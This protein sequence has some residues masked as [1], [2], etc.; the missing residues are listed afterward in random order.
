MSLEDLLNTLLRIQVWDIVK[1]LL[2]TALLI[3][4]IFALITIRQVELM[5]H[6]VGIT[7]TPALRLIAVVHFFISVGIF[8]LALFIL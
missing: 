6:V 2:E 7:L 3:Y 8:L 1:V 4:V 5:G